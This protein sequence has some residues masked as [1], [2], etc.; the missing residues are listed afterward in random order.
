MSRK[1]E[2]TAVRFYVLPISLCCTEKYDIK[3]IKSGEI[4]I[5]HMVSST[6]GYSGYCSSDGTVRY[7]QTTY[8]GTVSDQQSIK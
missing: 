5:A 3:N 7:T 1:E 2:C 4:D 8:Q 6:I